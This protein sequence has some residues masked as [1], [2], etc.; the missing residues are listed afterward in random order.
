MNSHESLQRSGSTKPRC[1]D[2][3]PDSDI[4]IM[5]EFDTAAHVTVF[6]YAG[7]K[8]YITSLFDGPVDV[9]N[10]DGLNSYVRAAALVLVHRR[11]LIHQTAAKLELAGV[12]HGIIAA[13]FAPNPEALVQLASLQTLVRRSDTLADVDLIIIDEAHHTRAKCWHSLVER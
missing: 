7:L 2:N 11:E 12:P 5:V 6:N 3:R 4:N 8:H 9:V 1:G 10:R 13:E